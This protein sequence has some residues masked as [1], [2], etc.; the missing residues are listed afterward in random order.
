[1]L[2][3][4][5][6]DALV[7]HSSIVNGWIESG[8]LGLSYPALLVETCHYVKHGCALMSAARARIGPESSS[9][10]RYLVGGV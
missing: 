6:E 5:L 10:Q 9:I 3:R 2:L 4:H 8:P 7:E 1:M